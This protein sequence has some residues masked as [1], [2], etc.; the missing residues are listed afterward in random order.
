MRIRV[1]VRAVRLSFKEGCRE[2]GLFEQVMALGQN[3]PQR[4]QLQAFRSSSGAAEE[5]ARTTASYGQLSCLNN[6]D[7]LNSHLMPSDRL[8][9]SDLFNGIRDIRSAIACAMDWAN[10]GFSSPTHR[11]SA[12][13]MPLN[14]N[15]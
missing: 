4:C 8:S 15:A 10:S 1:S 9:H 5:F 3:L 7:H 13:L 11:Y 6:R 14:V 12:P 2:A